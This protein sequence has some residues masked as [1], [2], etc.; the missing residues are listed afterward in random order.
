MTII[1]GK[2]SETKPF[3]CFVRENI[4][5]EIQEEIDKDEAWMQ[6]LKL[7]L[8]TIRDEDRKVRKNNPIKM[9]LTALTD[10]S[11]LHQL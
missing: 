3:L 9:S 7:I 6:K 8:M 10:R 1:S 5:K 11:A 2:W 4:Q